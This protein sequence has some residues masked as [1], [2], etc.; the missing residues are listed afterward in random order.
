ME[1]FKNVLIIVSG[2]R[3]KGS[4]VSISA[5]DL[6]GPLKITVCDNGVNSE[7]YTRDRFWE[8]VRERVDPLLD[9]LEAEDAD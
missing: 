9:Q 1:K 7:D 4:P 3:E 8:C 2:D 6:E 5:D